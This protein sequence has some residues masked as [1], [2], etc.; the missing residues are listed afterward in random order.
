MISLRRMF[1]WS[2]AAATLVLS[3]I[4]CAMAA[5]PMVN[6]PAGKLEGL[7]EGSLHV[8]KGIPYAMPPVDSRRWKPPAPMPRWAGVKKAI[9]FGPACYQPKPKVANLYTVDLGPMSEDCLTL[10]IWAPAGASK[11]P[12]FFWIHGGALWGGSS[13]ESAYDGTRIATQGHVIVVSINYRL[14]VLGWLAHPELSAE[15]PLGISGNYGLLDEI[16]RSN[17]SSKIFPLSV[18]IPRS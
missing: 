13:K 12:V 14:G 7:S 10:N 4:Y 3:P 17:G 16:K 8:F 2:A 11:M 9:E 6:A 15:S 1:V 5:Q 18:A